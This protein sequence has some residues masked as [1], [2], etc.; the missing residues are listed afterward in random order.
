MN[1]TAEQW[2]GPIREHSGGGGGMSVKRLLEV[3]LGIVVSLALLASAG[4]FYVAIQRD[5]MVT[6]QC[7]RAVDSIRSTQMLAAQWSVE[8]GKVKNEVNSNFDVLA[9]FVDRMS[10]HIQVIHDSQ[11]AMPDLPSDIKWALNGYVQRLKAR[12]ERIERFKSGFAIVRNSRRIIPREGALLAEAARDGG[13]G[14]VEAVTRQILERTQS[15]LGQPT[16]VQHQR[17]EQAARA[18]AENAAGTP[19]RNQAET[20]I[21]H[22]GAL[23]QHHRLTEQ[24]FEDVMRTDLEDRAERVIGLLDADH[25]QSRTKR[26]YLDYGFWVSLGIALFYWATLIVRWVRGRRKGKA[27]SRAP[28]AAQEAAPSPWGMDVA[29]A[30]AGGPGFPPEDARGPGHAGGGER[31]EQSRQPVQAQHPGHRT[32]AVPAFR[33]GAS[34]TLEE[35]LKARDRGEARRTQ[36]D[37]AGREDA[38]RDDA[39]RDDVGRDD[40]GRDDA[41]RDD[42]VR[43]DA[44]ERE[45]A[46]EVPVRGEEDARGS[47]P[48]EPS[49]KE[50]LKALKAELEVQKRARAQEAAL[51]TQHGGSMPGDPGEQEPAVPES[52]AAG[53]TVPAG[54][55]EDAPA[56]GRA[57][58]AL[59]GRP[60]APDAERGDRPAW[61][62]GPVPGDAEDAG[63]AGAFVT[64]GRDPPPDAFRDV[65]TSP[66]PE[67]RLKALEAEAGARQRMQEPLPP[68]VPEDAPAPGGGVTEGERLQAPADGDPDRL[69]VVAEEDARAAGLFQADG[70]S[71]QAQA[72]T[73]AAGSETEAAAA[74]RVRAEEPAAGTPQ[75]RA[76]GRS[77]GGERG[78]LRLQ[79]REAEEAPLPSQPDGSEFIHHAI[80]E[81]M[82]DRLREV[83]QEIRS[84][85]AAAE[86]AEH[87]RRSA[88]GEGRQD[89]GWAAAAGRMAGARWAV[90]TL[91]READ[92]LPAAP[93][94]R[95]PMGRV[96]MKALLDRRLGALAGEDRGRIDAT[97]V[98]GAVTRGN[99][100][101]LET[102]AD[103]IV[104]HALEGARLHPGG[105][106][107]VTLTLVREDDGVH[108]TCLDHG[109]EGEGSGE[110]RSLALAVARGLIE[111]QGGEMEITPYPRHG[112]MVRLRLPSDRSR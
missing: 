71:P 17:L 22:V 28:E 24:R 59:E 30:T 92:R 14:R 102:A 46:R 7:M 37:D 91:L 81:A 9:D 72:R 32:G 100:R 93:S 97:L 50:R 85:A 2:H 101:A 34:P 106:G 110:R 95:G 96:D 48:E 41:G 69:P 44:R 105:E 12:E 27:A 103:L 76:P 52:A 70:R 99:P 1:A 83:E 23:L 49:L 80:R 25:Q 65:R 33:G 35:R 55:E 79:G 53:R 20:L 104:Q 15:F 57:N 56:A 86:Q 26:R 31:P 62:G 112:T 16:E 63:D 58:L 13:H 3:A 78:E 94:P 4:F 109:P 67:D 45:P 77:G 11:S 64:E 19:L 66:V 68:P 75:A 40:V 82:L 8:V 111:G 54:R 88:D 36:R 98:P 87:A 84:A 10:P 47:G 60:A 74:V 39:G 38:G 29:L 89:A 18:L 108:L 90:H 61:R 42:A 5:E 43:E 51:R 107:Y 6:A 73:R 21:K